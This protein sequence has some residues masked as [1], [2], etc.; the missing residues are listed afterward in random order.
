MSLR[1]V[2]K[3]VGFVG[4]VI[5]L[6]AVVM[7]ASRVAAAPT[8]GPTNW[9]VLIE[10]NSYHDQYPDLPVGYINSTRMLTTLAR[11]GWPSDHL[12]LL[13]DNQDRAVLHHATGWLAARVRPGDLA[14]LYVAGEY[15][16]FDKDLMWD[17]TLPALWK[18]VPTSHRVLIA[19]TCFAERMTAVVRR[20]PGFG[21]PAVGRDERDWWGLRDTDRLIRGGAFTYFLAHALESQPADM[22]LDFAGAFGTAVTSAQ[23]Y[24]RTVIATTPGALDSF[25][26]MG[27]F[28]ERLATFPNPH[29]VEETADPVASTRATADP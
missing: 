1:Q 3:G 15:Q 4:V 23:A 8:S 6:A 24:F 14:L 18:R 26:A 5:L 20:I 28:P 19:E 25:H 7:G 13:R 29:L 9:A 11:R 12:L 10:Y 22:P 17:T 27:D 21:L 16:F 2:M